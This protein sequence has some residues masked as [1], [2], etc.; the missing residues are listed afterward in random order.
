MVITGAAEAVPE[1]IQRLVYFDAFL[2][3]DGECALVVGRVDA[4]EDACGPEGLTDAW[5]AAAVDG[6]VPAGWVPGDAP[7]PRDAPHPARTLTE[8]IQL[9]GDPG[10]GLPATYIITRET[11]GGEDGFEGSAE[12]A[13]TLGW[14]VVEYIGNHVPYREDPGGIARLFLAMQER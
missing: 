10:S 8:R 7:I 14:P 9:A 12:R 13:E 5:G 11:P 3:R 4:P 2:P 1:R 6:A